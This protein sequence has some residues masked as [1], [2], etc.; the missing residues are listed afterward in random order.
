MKLSGFFRRLSCRLSYMGLLLDNCPLIL[1]H[2]KYSS[3][4]IK[5]NIITFSYENRN[6]IRNVECTN[7]RRAHCSSVTCTGRELHSFN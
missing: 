4:A 1:Y 2:V 3:Q 6:D 7:F 5:K